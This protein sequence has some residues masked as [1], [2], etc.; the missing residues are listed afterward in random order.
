MYLR[1]KAPRGGD[2][3]LERRTTYLVAKAY[4]ILW[5]K[6]KRPGENVPL[7]KLIQVPWSMKT[8]LDL[9]LLV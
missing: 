7:L 6:N 9:C 8:M 4:Y 2:L 5:Y 1:A 3:G